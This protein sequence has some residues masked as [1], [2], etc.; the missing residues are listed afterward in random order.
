MGRSGV[1]ARRG[2]GTARGETGREAVPARRETET[3]RVRREAAE[4]AGRGTVTPGT[5]MVRVKWDLLPPTG[6]LL[7]DLLTKMQET[8]TLRGEGEKTRIG[9]RRRVQSWIDWR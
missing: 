5:R 2:G 9:K 7:G 4:T 3:V 6:A 8:E 1:V